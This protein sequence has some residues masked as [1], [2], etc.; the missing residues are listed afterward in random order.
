MLQVIWVIQNLLNFAQS[1]WCEVLEWNFPT[2]SLS[3]MSVKS[4]NNGEQIG[5]AN[6]PEASMLP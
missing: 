1:A 6:A 4:Q 5:K 3:V 2:F